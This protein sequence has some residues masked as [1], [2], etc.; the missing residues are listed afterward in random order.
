MFEPS[1]LAQQSLQDAYA[2]VIPTVRRRLGQ[3]SLPT[4]SMQSHAE[5]KAQ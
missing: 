1:R 3:A 5:R 2:C 4:P